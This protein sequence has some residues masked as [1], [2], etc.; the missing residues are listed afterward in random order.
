MLHMNGN[1]SI[2]FGDDDG[3]W[4][5]GQSYSL[6]LNR[7]ITSVIS[8]GGNVRYS[9]I[10][11]QSTKKTTTLSPSLTLGISNDLFRYNLSGSQ[12]IRQKGSEPTTTTSSWISSISTNFPNELWPQF[13]MSYGES[14]DSD[15]ATPSTVNSDSKNLT[16]GVD[17][18]W[19]TIK[20][21][22]NYT[23]TTDNDKISDSKSLS[24]GHST[25]VQFSKDLFD[26][27]LSVRG[28]HQYS[29]NT[30]KVS[31]TV[32]DGQVIV[33]LIASMA[34]SAIDNT[35][36]TGSLPA[37]PALNDQDL[38]TATTAEIPGVGDRLNLGLQ[39]D[40][41][42]FRRLQFYFDRLLTTTT[43]NRLHWTFYSSMDNNIWSQLS[44]NPAITYV[45]EDS[46]TIARVI[47]PADL[48]GIRYIKA[49]ITADSGLDTAYFAEILAQ[50][51]LSSS[52]GTVSNDYTSENY[53][54]SI[55][56]RPWE[57]FQIGYSFN[58]SLSDSDRSPLSTQDNH[59][60]S[61]HLNLNRFFIVSLSLSEND[62][63]IKGQD[64]NTNRSY[65]VSYQAN[66][67]D[68]MTFSLN[69]TRS[70]YYE[71]GTKER[72]TTGIS[73]TLATV[74]IPDLT[75][76]IS[77][78]SNVSKDYTDDSK[79]TSDTYTINLMARINPRLNLS[80]YYNYNEVGTHNASLLFHPSDQLSL[81]LSAM[82]TDNTENYSVSSHY[83]LT[84]KIQTDISYLYSITDDGNVYGSRFN[85]TW[86]ISSSLSIRQSLDWRKD[87]TE[88]R[89]AGLL[90]ISYNF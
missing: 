85:L 45:E 73:T 56:Y 1:W 50:D 70:D 87:T 14:R 44:T 26:D 18:S 20:M 15:D 72:R 17:Y 61:S 63:K 88:E 34:Y 58:R 27:R 90:S 21:L 36:L 75:T 33:D 86:D 32:V 62:D 68:T 43:Q 38:F 13:R 46:R 12:D 30:T 25:N 57:P 51:E 84:R 66:P 69:G 64:K 19:R 7:D 28:S 8:V 55:N 83:R 79:T 74:I 37:L 40:L 59:T 10:E 89:W 53:Q 16:A 35:P 22:Y 9:S 39:I 78:Q 49:V 80:Y 3:P 47:F 11:H 52:A 2:P 4:T 6:S 67:V 81:T 41:Q 24:I 82:L 29:I 42:T 48:S 65:A 23:Y 71:A 60:V 5:L 54:A 77:Y 31:T 76:N